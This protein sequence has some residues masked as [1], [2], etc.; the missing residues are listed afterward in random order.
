MSERSTV[1]P[2]RSVL[3]GRRVAHLAAACTLVFASSLSSARPF[4]SRKSHDD[5][6]VDLCTRGRW[7]ARANMA[8]LR[9]PEPFGLNVATGDL[10]FQPITFCRNNERTVQETWN[11]ICGGPCRLARLIGHSAAA[12][13]G[14]PTVPPPR[15][16][17]ARL[18]HLHSPYFSNFR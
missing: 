16:V 11:L 6:L 12:T 18:S 13:R 5:R 14:V 15:L 4:V 1:N 3:T 2:N 7:I 17:A 8:L 10:R 9:H